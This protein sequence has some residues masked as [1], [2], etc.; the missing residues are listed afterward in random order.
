MGN[1]NKTQNETFGNQDPDVFDES[2]S[3]RTDRKSVVSQFEKRQFKPTP[4]EEKNM[5]L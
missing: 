5:A 2:L 1:V 4:L 3:M